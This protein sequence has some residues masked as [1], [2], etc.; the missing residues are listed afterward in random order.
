M[1]TLIKAAL[2]GALAAST[3]ISST[4]RDSAADVPT[5]MPQL[6]TESAVTARINSSTADAELDG[7]V[8]VQ[9]EDLRDSIRNELLLAQRDPTSMD[10]GMLLAQSRSQIEAEVRGSTSTSTSSSTS[11]ES[12]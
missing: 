12:E 10:K 1:Q 2:L 7:F 4:D 6:A 9:T 11:T 8:L 5:V 3:Q